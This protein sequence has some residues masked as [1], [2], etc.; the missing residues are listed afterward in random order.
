MNEK[1]RNLLA[2]GDKKSIQAIITYYKEQDFLTQMLLEEWLVEEINQKNSC[3]MHWLAALGETALFTTLLQQ[4]AVFNKKDKQGNL[5][6]HYATLHKHADIVETILIADNNYSRNKKLATH[7]LDMF[8]PNYAGKTPAAI[9]QELGNTTI[10]NLFTQARQAFLYDTHRSQ[11]PTPQHTNFSVTNG[12]SSYQPNWQNVACAGLNYNWLTSPTGQIVS[13]GR[14]GTVEKRFCSGV[15]IG[16]NYFLTAGHCLGDVCY[17]ITD[18]RAV[19]YRVSFNYQLPICPST[20]NSAIQENIY[21]LTVVEHG[22]CNGIDYAVFKLDPAAEKYFG[23]ANLTTH[24][25][26]IGTPVAIS[27]HP[28]GAPKKLSIGSVTSTESKTGEI[29]HSA[30]TWWGSS[31]SPVADPITHKVHAIHVQGTADQKFHAALSVRAIAEKST[32]V[33]AMTKFGLLSHAPTTHV[34]TYQDSRASTAPTLRY[35]SSTN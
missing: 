26:T 28:D 18:K 34:P 5:P 16:N 12:S 19:N 3:F 7:S 8:Q 31:G 15:N 21:S 17:S 32:I 4:K 29:Q 22:T 33:G 2:K 27:H 14:D 9:A 24:V 25:P 35:T 11:H 23:H 10:I 1:L 30:H 13:V 20:G 6:L